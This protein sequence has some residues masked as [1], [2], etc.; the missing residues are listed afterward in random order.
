[1]NNSR[2][3]DIIGLILTHIDGTEYY[4]NYVNDDTNRIGLAECVSSVTSY[5]SQAEFLNYYTP[6]LSFYKD[7]EDDTLYPLYSFVT[8]LGL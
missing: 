7:D 2:Y 5:M 1:M 4:I 8:I 6:Y 3:K